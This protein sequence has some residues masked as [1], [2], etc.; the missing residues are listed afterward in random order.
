VSTAN[1]LP[2]YA[3]LS[4]KFLRKA[5]RRRNTGATQ[6]VEGL[7]RFWLVLRC[8]MHTWSWPRA[9]KEERTPGFD[10]HQT[11]HK[12]TSYRMFNTQQWQAGPV[13]RRVRG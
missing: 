10:A 3:R 12:C 7:D 1:I 6:I 4:Q 2:I 11:C 5:V 13:Y 8:P 9:N